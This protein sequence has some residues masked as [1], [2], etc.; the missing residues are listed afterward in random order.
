MMY[1]FVFEW[2][3]E[4]LSGLPTFSPTEEYIGTVEG[5]LRRMYSFV[6]EW[7]S[8]TIEGSCLL[9]HRRKNTSV[10]CRVVFV[11]CLHSCLSGCLIL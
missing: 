11:G 10:P 3:S 9:L 2:V 6:F 1:L 5:C 4:T 7:V 8:E